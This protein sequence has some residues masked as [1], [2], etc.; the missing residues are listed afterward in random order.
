MPEDAADLKHHVDDVEFLEVKE[1]HLDEIL[2]I[3][4]YYVVN[5]T[6][7]LHINPISR[8]KMRSI[9]LFENPSYRTYVIC[10]QKS[11]RG[12]VTVTQYKNREAYDETGEVI[13]YLKPDCIGE[14]LGSLALQFIEK[15]A[16]E[17]SFHVL[18]AVVCDENKKSIKLFERNGYFK[19][20]HYKEVGKKFDHYMDVVAFQKIIN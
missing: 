20:G 16:K 10:K 3:Y 14:G 18:M 2:E 12:Y 7:T 19:C 1:E 17:H 4:N 13:I 11:I 9:V 5:T 15:H 8:E 6:A